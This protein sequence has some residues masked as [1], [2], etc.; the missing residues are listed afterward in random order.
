MGILKGM[1]LFWMNFCCCCCRHLWSPHLYIYIS[2]SPFAFANVPA[3]F[4][5]FYFLTMFVSIILQWLPALSCYIYLYYQTT[6][7]GVVLTVCNSWLS[8]VLSLL[9]QHLYSYFL[10]TSDCIIW[11]HISVFSDDTGLYCL[12]TLASVTSQH[13]P[14]C[15]ISRFLCRKILISST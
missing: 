6:F 13:L 1:V 7:G 11:L 15:N 8:W 9:F 3:S 14:A 12:T 10:I 2:L 5:F 4:L